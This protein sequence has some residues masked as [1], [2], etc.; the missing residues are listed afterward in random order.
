LNNVN[1]DK[2]I[3]D[4]E[5]A[6]SKVKNGRYKKPSRKLKLFFW[7]ILGFL[8]VF[9]AEVISGSDMFPFFLPMSIIVV[10]P[11]YTL[12]ILVLSHIVIKQGKPNI[13][14]LFLAGMLFGL[15]EAYITKVLWNPPWDET[16][17][18]IG[19]IA[20][21]EFFMLVFWWHAFYSFIIPLFLSENLLTGSREIQG[22]QPEK[23]QNIFNSK[24]KTY[25]LLVVFAIWAGG[26]QS[27][28][29]INPFYSIL[30]GLSTTFVIGILILIWRRKTTGRD[31]SIYDL[32]PNQN[33][34]RVIFILLII[35]YIIIGIFLRPEA[36]PDI[37]GQ[38]TI[39][40]IY[41]IIFILLFFHLRRSKDEIS[42]DLITSN[43]NFSWKLYIALALI[44][45]FSSATF[46]LIPPITL[47]CFYTGLF[48][49]IGISIILFVAS[50][51]KLIKKK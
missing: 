30:S 8:S 15:Y 46:K 12:H 2:L 34:F 31:Y 32:V 49:G 1:Y 36:F 48:I 29:S 28:N 19:G 10:I 20:V 18:K 13:Y 7:I 40:I 25:V 6:A 51:I 35:Y 33:E 23:I 21:T 3:E 14:T 24:K 22:Y 45:T 43:I 38:V 11:L 37:W 5:N 4:F 27:L 44:F 41:S 47:F 50:I 16:A 17:F 9:F 39:W 26:F 42:N